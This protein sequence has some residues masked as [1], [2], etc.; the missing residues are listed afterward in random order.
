VSS[1]KNEDDYHKAIEQGVI[2]YEWVQK[3]EMAKPEVLERLEKRKYPFDGS[4]L[5]WKPD[6][7][8]SPPTLPEN[9]DKI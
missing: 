8:W 2:L 3:I 5:D 7:R 1:L 6:P 4:W 9:W